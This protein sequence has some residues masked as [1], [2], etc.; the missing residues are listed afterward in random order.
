LPELAVRIR[1]LHDTDRSGWWI[2][3]LWVPQLLIGVAAFTS[4]WGMEPG[5]DTSEGVSLLIAS[6]FVFLAG[7]ITFLVFMCLEGT[8]GKNRFGPDSKGFQG[9]GDGDDVW[10]DV[11]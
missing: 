7:G 3:I 4:V 2:L 9:A 8:R 11:A 10:P 6:G 1:R 5:D